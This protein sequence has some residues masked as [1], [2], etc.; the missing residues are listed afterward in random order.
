[1][2]KGQRK[3]SKKQA[4]VL[5]FIE[6]FFDQH[7]RPPTVRE[8]QAGCQMSSTAVVDH[9]LTQLEKK[10]WIRREKGKARGI[11]LLRPRTQEEE[12][13]LRIPFY[14]PIAA[15]KPIPSSEEHDPDDYISIPRDL[16]GSIAANKHDKLFALR[17]QG[18]SMIDAL[19]G[20]GD[21]VICLRDEDVRNGQMVAAWL[22]DRNEATLK[23]YH[24]IKPAPAPVGKDGYEDDFAQP[25]PDELAEQFA[26][27]VKVR[28][29]PANKAYSPVELPPDQVEI[30]GRVVLVIRVLA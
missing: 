22:K 29:V 5:D 26:A 19:V 25:D 18:D 20:D 24:L 8:I 14:G 1:M 28:L 6:K 11:T 23:Y 9:Y 21:L 30:H 17:V 4:R 16:L 15:G 10:G 13:A 7:E 2:S 27:Q 12:N 3:L